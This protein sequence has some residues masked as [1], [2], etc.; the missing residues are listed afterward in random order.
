MRK[1]R[2]PK[3]RL[4]RGPVPPRPLEWHDCRFVLAGRLYFFSPRSGMVFFTLGMSDDE[5]AQLKAALR[6]QGREFG[7]RAELNAYAVAHHWPNWTPL[8]E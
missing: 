3:D 1:R 7:T 6:A 2:H 8:G 5:A 4:P